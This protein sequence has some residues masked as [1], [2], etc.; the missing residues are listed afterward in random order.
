MKINSRIY[1]AGHRGLVGSAIYRLLK[2]RGFENLIT[3]THS[4]LE[5]MDAVA[6]QNFFEETKPEFVFLAAAKV[7]GIH[8]NSTYP[9]NFIRENLVVQTNVIHESW[10]NDVEKLMFLGSSC[11][12]PKLCPQPIS[13]ES[14][15]TGEL[16]PT[17][18]AYAL[19]KIAGIK[20][21]QSYNQQYGT[22]FISA[23]PTNLYGINDN[24]HPENSHVLPALIRRFHEAKLAD[25]E[26]I[27][28]WG[29]GNPRRE[30]LHSDDLADAVLF[31][32]E[33][34]NDSEIVNIGCGEDQTIRV[35][36]ETI[37][38]VVG[39]SGSLEFDSSRPDG[40]PQKML[41]ISKIRVLGWTP[42]IP[43]KNGLEQVYQWYKEH[44]F[45]ST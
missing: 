41:D 29:T 31:L 1:V 42:A 13:E 9:A 5:L 4:E 35:L 21:C 11:I 15:L 33:N 3:R 12:Y 44:K 6:V 34:Y 23:M 30:F 16:E 43:L 10:R 25:S 19:A 20:T 18:E 37:R 40:T 28:I 2:K 7:G 45:S 36:A 32:M 26:S 8:A 17:N 14:L 27:S 38:E 39:Y 22:T 24:F